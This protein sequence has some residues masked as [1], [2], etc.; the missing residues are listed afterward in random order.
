VH[1]AIEALSET[2]REI[3]LYLKNR[4]GATIAELS[5]HLG[6]SDEGT[7]QHL[8][9]LEKNGW[10]VRCD[11]RDG[12]G[13]SGRPASHYRVSGSGET[14]FPKQYGVLSTTLMDIVADL[15]GN[16]AI[17]AALTRMTDEK[18]HEWTT[19]LEGKSLQERVDM[20]RD[21]YR[22]GDEF[23]SVSRENGSMAIVERNCPFLDVANAKPALCSTTTSVLTRLLGCEVRRRRTFQN[24]DGCC[25]FEILA[26]RPVDGRQFNFAFEDDFVS[27]A[28]D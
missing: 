3:L 16:T 28:D 21:Y 2:R 5:A 9:H 13:R 19:R 25:E 8:I 11:A 20:L 7:R 6:I 1:E 15:Y 14:F 17:E 18:V 24:G 26:D 27:A 23:T 4:G 10:V 12:T 22:E